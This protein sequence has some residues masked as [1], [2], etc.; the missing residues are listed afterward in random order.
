MHRCLEFPR[1][2]GRRS[3]VAES[4]VAETPP[5]AGLVARLARARAQTDGSERSEPSSHYSGVPQPNLVTLEH[6]G[7]FGTRRSCPVISLGWSK[8]S[9]PRTVGEMS[10]NDPSGRSVNSSEFSLTTMKG[11]GLV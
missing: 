3:E 11:T 5:V 4:S 2:R 10:C 6:H 8:P 1:G 7:V 9:I